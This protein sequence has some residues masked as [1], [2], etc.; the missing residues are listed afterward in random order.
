LILDDSEGQHYN[1]NCMGVLQETARL[2]CY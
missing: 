2:S 1:K